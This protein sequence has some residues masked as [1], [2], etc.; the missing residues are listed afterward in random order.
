MATSVSLA[1]VH[2]GHGHGN[3]APWQVV[4]AYIAVGLIGWLITAIAVLRHEQAK[5]DEPVTA[6]GKFMAVMAGLITCVGWPL[7]IVGLGVWK[8]IDAFARQPV[9]MTKSRR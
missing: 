6:D 7:V 8:A 1:L 3:D 2:S 5:S 4:V 9:N